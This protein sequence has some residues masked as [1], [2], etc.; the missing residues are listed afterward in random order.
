MY[1]IYNEIE[2]IAEIVVDKIF[3]LIAPFKEVDVNINNALKQ[4]SLLVKSAIDLIK[5][6]TVPDEI[7]I[8]DI[9]L[10]I[11]NVQNSHTLY[12]LK[13][14][15]L[16]IVPMTYVTEYISDVYSVLESI[17][18]VGCI[19]RRF[20]DDIHSTIIYINKYKKKKE[21]YYVYWLLKHLEYLK[22]IKSH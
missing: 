4:K 15:V 21:C 9:H 18:N 1:T 19:N 13:K 6:N 22:T 16:D 14:A 10:F 3:E 11:N 17:M 12:H 7:T 8:P 20:P 2:S 5:K